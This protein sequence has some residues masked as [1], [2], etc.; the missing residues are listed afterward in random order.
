MVC[1]TLHGV[2]EP[3]PP[4]P[5]TT[6]ATAPAKAV[7]GSVIAVAIGVMNIAT[8]GFTI[9]AARALGPQQYGAFAAVMNLLARRQRR[10][11]RAAGHRRAPDRVDTG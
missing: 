6:G 1:E 5:G 8:Y 10:L 4:S 2:S 3:S 11:A 9:V 7:N